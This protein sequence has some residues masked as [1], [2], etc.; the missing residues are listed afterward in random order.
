VV[1]ERDSDTNIYRMMCRPALSEWAKALIAVGAIL[2]VLM[3][4][5]MIWFL[6]KRLTHKPSWY[7]KKMINKHRFQSIP[8]EGPFSVVITDIEGYSGKGTRFS[9]Q[10]KPM[11]CSV[12]GLGRTLGCRESSELVLGALV[13]SAPVKRH[14]SGHGHV[15]QILEFQKT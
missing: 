2:F 4:A 8:K 12:A 11:C 7:Y 14:C 10:I 13:S 3:C 15:T 6:I 9:H 5:L 1:W